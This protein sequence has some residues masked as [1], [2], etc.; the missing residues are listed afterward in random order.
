MRR[1][2]AGRGGRG[3]GRKSMRK[4]ERGGGRGGRKKMR[5]GVKGAK[6]GEQEE[7]KKKRKRHCTSTQLINLSH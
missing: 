6:G 7:L 2:G 5:R 4:E 3:E 1:R